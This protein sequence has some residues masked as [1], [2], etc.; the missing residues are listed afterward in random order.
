M[1][2][3]KGSGTLIKTKTGLYIAKWMFQGKVYTRSTQTYVE[4]EAYDKLAEFTRPYQES[5]TIAVIENL[6]AKVRTIEKTR[7][8][9][10][11]PLTEL[12]NRY[13]NN[14]NVNISKRTRELRKSIFN[15]FVKW[16]TK[17]HPEVTTLDRITKP[18]MEEFLQYHQTHV[19]ALTYN[20]DLS[21]LRLMFDI[22]YKKDNVL[23]TFQKKKLTVTERR[24]ITKEEIQKVLSACRKE[25]EKI[26]FYT[27]AYTG[28]RVSDVCS[29]KWKHVNMEKGCIEKVAVKTGKPF[30]VPLHLKL[31]EFLTSIYKEQ[32]P[33]EYVSAKL[34]KFYSYNHLDRTIMRIYRRSGINMTGLRQGGV[35]VFRHAFC[36][37]CANG[38][39]PVFSLMKMLGHTN[40]QTTLR[41]YHQFNTNELQDKLCAI[42]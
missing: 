28:M 27:L 8:V 31:K 16:F 38:G 2:R 6:S 32:D 36:S 13:I 15:R 19:G 17:N 42:M 20:M 39:I 12:F 29:L 9:E 37:S 21:Y 3:Q 1:K 24:I 4:S 26:L 35:H 40:V 11:I 30:I 18:L 7:Q 34:N 10:K 14:I 25:H 22:V 23:H 5:N 33:E 41:Y